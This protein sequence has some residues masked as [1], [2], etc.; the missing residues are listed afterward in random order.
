LRNNGDLKA[1]GNVLVLT[2]SDKGLDIV[3]KCSHTI[4]SPIVLCL[5]SSE[6]SQE[7]QERKVD[8]PPQ[9]GPSDRRKLVT[10]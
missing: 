7:I 4:V 5:Q 10:K 2:L 6:L 3:L 8:G 9:G 1:L